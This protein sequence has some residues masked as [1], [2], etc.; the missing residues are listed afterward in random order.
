VQ[1]RCAAIPCVDSSIPEV[2]SVSMLHPQRTT[3]TPIAASRGRDDWRSRADLYVEHIQNLRGVDALQR[4]P[5]RYGPLGFQAITA[6]GH[7]TL[8]RSRER[9]VRRHRASRSGELLQAPGVA[10]G[11][12]QHAGSS[13]ASGTPGPA[14]DQSTSTGGSSTPSTTG[15]AASRPCRTAGGWP[16]FRVILRACRRRDPRAGVHEMRTSWPS[17]PDRD[18]VQVPQGHR[19]NR[20]RTVMLQIATAAVPRRDSRSGP[21]R[22]RSESRVVV[23]QLESRV[24]S[25]LVR[26]TGARRDS[27]PDGHGD[28][29]SGGDLDAVADLRCPRREA[30]SPSHGAPEG[31]PV[32]RH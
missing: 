12:P 6:H 13:D 18:V 28:L 27:A 2:K 20:K 3:S 25:W 26:G 15:T 10:L 14:S 32:G 5:D 4:P 19:V 24:L 16:P 17:H 23:G 22:R 8:W 9:G 1:S 29:F 31:A 11:A 7:G 21:R 30:S